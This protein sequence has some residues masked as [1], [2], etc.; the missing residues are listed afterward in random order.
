MSSRVAVVELRGAGD[1]DA[2]LSSRDRC[3][4]LFVGSGRQQAADAVLAT[5][6]DLGVHARIGRAVPYGGAA[7]R[8]IREL[9]MRIAHTDRAC[10]VL[11]RGTAVLDVL[12]STDVE[13]HG[14]QWAAAQFALRFVPCL[15]DGQG[16]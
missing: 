12:R 14:A 15:A 5:L 1:V 4:A 11:L 13:A 10:L 3:V 9:V 2:F 16:R 8:R 6:C 7:D